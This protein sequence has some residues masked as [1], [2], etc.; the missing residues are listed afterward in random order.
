MRSRPKIVGSNLETR[1]GVCFERTVHVSTE[2]LCI[3]GVLDLMEVETKTG[4]LKLV[5]YKLDKPKSDPMD[6]IQL[7]AQGLCLE[8]MKE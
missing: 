2:K 4:S 8:E 5:E 3:S 6:E 1:K 7:C